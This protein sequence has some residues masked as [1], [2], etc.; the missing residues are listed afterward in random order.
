MSNQPPC[1]NCSERELGCHSKCIKYVSWYAARRKQLD[2][3]NRKR[4]I[5]LG[6]RHDNM[7]RVRRRKG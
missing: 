1:Y 4:Y 7:E 2:E 6:Y 5:D 3:V